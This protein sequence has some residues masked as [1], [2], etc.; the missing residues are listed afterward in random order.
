MRCWRPGMSMLERDQAAIAATL[1]HGPD[2]LPADIFAGDAAAVLRGLRVHAN[3]VSHARLV[4][5]ED[6]FPR[7][8]GYLGEAAF[9]RLSR[10]FVEAGGAE[11]RSLSDI[12]AAF[13][14]WLADPLAAD[15]ARIEWAW[16]QSYHAAEAPA[17]AI[18]DLAGLDEAAL[19][20]LPVRRHPAVHVVALSAAAAPLVNPAFAHEVETVLAARPDAEVRL[21]AVHAEEATALAMVGEISPLGNLIAHLA[22]HHPDGVAAVAALIGAGALEKTG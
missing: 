1:L 21:H 5:L 16:L 20:A 7:T 8:R 19:L 17:L 4:A 11:G 6:T 12:G 3:T 2:H 14:D 15:L 10:A 18:A 9:N 13:P 22:E